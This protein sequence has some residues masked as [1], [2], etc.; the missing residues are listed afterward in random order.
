MLN[1]LQ[2]CRLGVYAQGKGHKMRNNNNKQVSFVES[3]L[4]YFTL[5]SSEVSA[6]RVNREFQSSL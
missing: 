2:Y 5:V 6:V 1:I 4:E 3:W